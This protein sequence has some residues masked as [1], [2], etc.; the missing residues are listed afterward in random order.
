MTSN[1]GTKDIK[2]TGGIGFSGGEEKDQYT[3]LKNTVEDAMKRLFNPEFLNRIDESIVFRSLNID[4]IK[5]IIKIEIKDLMQNVRENKME[6]ELDQ[7]AEDFL[8]EKG[9]D[10]KYGARPLNRAI[11]KYLEDPLAEEMLMNRVKEGEKITVKHKKDTEELYFV[12]EPMEKEEKEESKKKETK[13]SKNKE[14]ESGENQNEEDE[15]EEE[16][17]SSKA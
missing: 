5:K 12:S 13:G 10:P 16:E 2:A 4:D 8:A 9:F 1:V 14:S 15:H 6:L 11:Q 3:N 17:N 7:S